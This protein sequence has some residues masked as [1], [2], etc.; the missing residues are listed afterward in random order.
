MTTPT[1]APAGATR[2][3]VDDV[4]AGRPPQLPPGFRH[5][6]HRVRIGHGEHVFEAAG[7]AIMT[8]RLHRAVGVRPQPSAPRAAPDV[9]VVSHIPIATPCVVVWTLDEPSRAGFGYGTTAGHPFSGEE[10]FVASLDDGGNVWFTV[11]A[12]SRP[13]RWFTRAA[14]PVAPLFQ[15]AYA[16]RCASV[17][18]RLANAPRD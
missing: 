7:E 5:L 4:L 10:S 13:A 2:Q 17:L 16:R 11:V 1:Y 9:T 12:F 3:A 14:G 18:R 6:H 8:W 15:K